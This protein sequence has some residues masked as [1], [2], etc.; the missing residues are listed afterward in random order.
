MVCMYVCVC[1]Y[2]YI[3]R[4]WHDGLKV[5]LCACQPWEHVL[6]YMCVYVCMCMCMYVHEEFGRVHQKRGCVCVNLDE[7]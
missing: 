7:Q 4:G 3:R 6:L 1:T 2:V 5:M